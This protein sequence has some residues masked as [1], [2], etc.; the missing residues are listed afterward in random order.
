MRTQLSKLCNACG[1][2]VQR[3]GEKKLGDKSRLRLCCSPEIVDFGS[4]MESNQALINI[5][6]LKSQ[7]EEATSTGPVRLGVRII[8]LALPGSV[9]S[10]RSFRMSRK[11]NR[12]TSCSGSWSPTARRS[13]ELLA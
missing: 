11:P 4:D 7:T 12:Q 1:V 9:S 6:S 13:F 5:V 3:H 10:K 8:G 2:R